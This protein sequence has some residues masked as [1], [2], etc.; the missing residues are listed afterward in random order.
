ML[1]A[2]PEGRLVKLAPDPLGASTVV[3]MSLST[4]TFDPPFCS[5]PVKLAASS[6]LAVL[7]S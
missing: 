6:S 4:I 1:V 7:A 5:A 2:P 3:P